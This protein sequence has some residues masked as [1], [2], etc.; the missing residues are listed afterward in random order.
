MTLPMVV[1]TGRRIKTNN[2]IRAGV[3]RLSTPPA[4]RPLPYGPQPSP[5][6]PLPMSTNLNIMVKSTLILIYIEE[7]RQAIPLLRH[8]PKVE[9]VTCIT[10]PYAP[11]PSPACLRHSTVRPPA[12]PLRAQSPE[13]R[14]PSTSVTTCLMSLPHLRL[15]QDNNNR[16]T[17]LISLVSAA[18]SAN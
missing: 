18:N 15:I 11:R 5:T 12:A 2:T 4:L 1:G 17:P 8:F 3:R 9:E 10:V 7:G 6:V 16:R 13:A 14:L